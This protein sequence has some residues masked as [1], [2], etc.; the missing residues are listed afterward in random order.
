MYRIYPGFFFLAVVAILTLA[1]GD[2]WAQAAETPENFKADVNKAPNF[3]PYV[4][5]AYGATCVLLFIFS[6]RCILQNRKLEDRIGHLEQ[7]FLD[8]G[9]GENTG[10]AES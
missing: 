3:Q 7:R 8:S 6:L 5:Y 1:G 2:L 9:E 4:F 10:K